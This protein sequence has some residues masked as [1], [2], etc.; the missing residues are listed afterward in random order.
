MNISSLMN[1]LDKVT[2]P[3]QAALYNQPSLQSVCLQW[4]P[5]TPKGQSVFWQFNTSSPESCSFRLMP[6]GCFHFLFK[7][8]PKNPNALVSCVGTKMRDIELEKDQTYFCVT[9]YSMLGTYTT[10]AA[11]ADMVDNIVPISDLFDDSER[12]L[13]R[14]SNASRFEDRV[15]MFLNY[16]NDNIIN[17]DYNAGITDYLAILI[18]VNGGNLNFDSAEKMLGYSQRHCRNLFKQSYGISP[19][20][21][22]EIIRFQNALK[23]LCEYDGELARLANDVGYYDQAHF[24]RDFKTFSGYTPEALRK[25]LQFSRKSSD[26]I[27]VL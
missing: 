16:A 13:E 9:P 26:L 21:Y 8:D 14:I 10:N 7:C 1:E 15:S 6:D 17:P 4:N 19:K 22:S 24:T 20:K 11:L 2:P 3:F 25:S 27:S 5:T 12:L 23:A 18:C